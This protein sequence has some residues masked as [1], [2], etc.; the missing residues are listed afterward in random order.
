MKDCLIIGPSTVLGYHT[1]FEYFRSKRLKVGHSGHKER[2]GMYF[3]YNEKSVFKTALWFT[4]LD[5]R[6]FENEFKLTKHYEE[7]K[8]QH[9]DNYPDIIE[10]KRC[11]DIPTD[12]DGKMGVSITFFRYYPETDYEVLE[13]NDKCQLEGKQLFKRLIIRKRNA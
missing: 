6:G 4:T 11:N 2:I 5:V 3:E 1:L 8:F 7:G 9:Y 10:V 12:Y 13:L